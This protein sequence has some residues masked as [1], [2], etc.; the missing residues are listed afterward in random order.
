MNDRDVDRFLHLPG[1]NG[2]NSFLGNKIAARDRRAVHGGQHHVHRRVSIAGPLEGNGDAA[3]ILI[4]EV[5]GLGEFDGGRAQAALPR[6]PARSEQG[7]N[8]NQPDLFQR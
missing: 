4:D 8:D 3:G 2:Y 7:R 1:G 6:R 5:S